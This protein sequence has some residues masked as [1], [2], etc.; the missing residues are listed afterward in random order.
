MSLS[1]I[2]DSNDELLLDPRLFD[3]DLDD[4]LLESLWI[5]D[6]FGE[7]ALDALCED[8]CRRVLTIDEILGYQAIAGVTPAPIAY[9]P[10]PAD[11]LPKTSRCAA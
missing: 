11:Q 4:C 7:E 2:E 5:E 8:W 9:L 1:D 10:I 6:V 3:E